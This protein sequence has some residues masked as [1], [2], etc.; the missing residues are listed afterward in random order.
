MAFLDDGNERFYWIKLY[1]DFF[2]TEKISYLLDADWEN[3]SY[4]ILIYLQLCLLSA[5]KG[6]KLISEIDEYIVPYSIKKITR[7][8]KYFP[9]DVVRNAVQAFIQLGLI[10][11]EESGALSLVELPKMVGYESADPAT[12]R[13]RKRYQ[14][15]KQEE[16]EAKLATKTVKVLDDIL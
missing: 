6:G 10:Y 1:T 7:E 13:S 3:G 15:K 12:I 8:L 2:D 16:L 11:K 14:K 4:Y 9:E 5:N